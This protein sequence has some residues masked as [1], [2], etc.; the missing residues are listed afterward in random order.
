MPR[1][2]GVFSSTN[3]CVITHK[4]VSNYV[5]T[6]PLFKFLVNRTQFFEIYRRLDISKFKLWGIKNCKKTQRL[7]KLVLGIFGVCET[8]EFI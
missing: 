8:K 2:F 6:L 3:H 5:N 4:H 7:T 1:I